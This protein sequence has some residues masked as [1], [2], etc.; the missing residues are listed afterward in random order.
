MS[1][2]L[3][4]VESPAKAKSIGKL[5]GKKYT[6]KASMGH[7]RDLPKS[8]FGVDVEH[9]FT[10][11]YIT[12]RGKGEI[13]KELKTAVK[14]ADRV[15]L[16][17]DPDREGEAI[18]WHLANVLEIDE[19]APCRIEFNEIT[20][21]A[22]QNAVKAP[23]PIDYNRVNAQQAR[24]ILDRLV[25]YKLSPLLWRKVKK[26][27]SAGR[28]QS[29]AVRLICDRE[30]EIN[31]FV[32]EEYWTLTAVFTRRGKDPFEAKLYKIGDK[33]AEIKN[34]VQIGEI[35]KDLKGVSYRVVKITHR[36]KNRQPAP[37]FTT[38]SLQQEAYRKLNFTARKT[39]MVAQQLYEGLELG[40]EGP[41]GLVTY[42]RTDSTRV[43]AQALTDARAY[44]QEKFGP[45]Y[46][47]EK[48]RQVAARGRV[49]DAHEAIRPT[50]VE[51]EPEAIKHYLT[52]DQYKLYKLIWS[53]F[54]ASQM[55]PAIIETTSIDITGGRYI[56]R[57]TGSVVKFPGFTR[58]YVESRDDETKEEEG[59]LPALSEG[60][61]LEVKSL[62]PKQHFTQPPPRYT[63]A[64]LVKAL[65]EKGIGRP[66]TYAPILETIIK[67]GY[68]VRE[69]K[70]L[71]PT[72]LG[73]VVVDLLKKH[74]PDIIDVEFTAQMEE[75]LDRIEEG[76]MDWVRVIQDFYGPFQETLARAEEKIGQVTVSDEVSEEI[77]EQCGR[78]MVVKMGRYGKFLA[79][80][81][82][83]EC[84]NTRPLLE[85]TGVPCP[86]CKGELVV[87][88]S[89]KG[90]KF[91]GCS[92]Y[93]DCDFVVW[94]EPSGEKCP[95]CGG[96]LVIKR[97]RGE[98]EELECIN[99]RCRYRVGREKKAGSD[100]QAARDVAAGSELAEEG[101][102]FESWHGDALLSPAGAK[103][104][105]TANPGT[106]GRS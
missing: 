93:P 102:F 72:E 59:V 44:I 79:C 21:Q 18:A 9:G 99:E 86:Q 97:G 14:K 23:R 13:I 54:V 60:E 42:I 41:V 33:K 19:N 17:S 28:V 83:P 24:R 55:S 10:P 70:Q 38:S 71:V 75:S 101:P 1:K 27:L 87:R 81:G 103:S 37:P 25:G 26:G 62:T 46:V 49:Q 69:K 57:A 12:I 51:R 15:L 47:P 94:D 34:Q 80:P 20:K 63:D 77:C 52:P 3:V 84:R 98:Q 40:K 74:F 56:F 89:K 91:Y 78:N 85:P 68:V 31:A 48:P 82:F 53:R 32:P 96:L 106:G 8:Q 90:R 36:E 35:L 100:G 43:A 29:V 105:R 5:L 16:A 50:A 76:E 30:E 11:K 6:I 45:E 67:R 61:A 73:I 88:R 22:V 95:R 66:S 58:V 7:V 2:T 39:M 104:S 4:I 92:R 65:E 64:T